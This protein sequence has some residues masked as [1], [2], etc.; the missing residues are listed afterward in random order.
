MTKLKNNK[1]PFNSKF[2]IEPFVE[3][4][5]EDFLQISPKYLE[6]LFTQIN[7]LAIDNE[8]NLKTIQDNSAL[9]NSFFSLV[10]PSHLSKNELKMIT[11][12]MGEELLFFSEKLKQ[13]QPE[14]SDDNKVKFCNISEDELYKYKCILLLN[15]L[16]ENKI[17]YDK[18]ITVEFEDGNGIFKSFIVDDNH[19]F[20]KIFPN[21]PKNV[22]TSNQINELLDD[23]DNYEL[24]K[25]LFPLNSWT[26][27]GFSIFTLI[28]NTIDNAVSDLKTNLL[29]TNLESVFT[30][31]IFKKIFRSI[32]GIK[33][34]KVGVT[35]YNHDE[36]ILI[37][38]KYNNL[39]IDSFI[40]NK[41]E[42]LPISDYKEDTIV[43]RLLNDRQSIVVQDI[44]VYGIG[45]PKSKVIKSLVEQDIKSLIIAPIVSHGLVVGFFEIVSESKHAI[46][47]RNISKLNLVL[48]IVKNT[49]D[50]AIE[51]NKNKIDAIIQNEY[52]SIHKSV[53]WKFKSQASQFLKSGKDIEEYN[54]KDIIFEDVHALFGQIDIK[55]SSENRLNASKDD[56][57]KQLDILIS[58]FNDISKENNLL[59]V[60]QII[61]ELN[62]LADDIENNYEVNSESVFNRYVQ[63]EVHP[64]LNTLE[65]SDKV[66]NKIELYLSQMDEQLNMIYES[67]RKYDES[68]TVLNKKIA[69]YLDKKQIEAQ[70]IFPHYY[71]RYATDGI[72]HNLYIGASIEPKKEFSTIYLNNLRLWQLKTLCETVYNY[73]KWKH[74]LE[75]PLEV[76]T[77]ILVFSTPLNIRFRLEEKLFDVDGSYNARYEVV[78]KRIDKS[79][80]KNTEERITQP[81]KITIVY[82]QNDEKLEYLK[83]LKYLISEDLLEP[84][85]EKLEVEDLQSVT[86]LKALRVTV[87]SID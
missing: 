3:V 78:K 22:P 30:D 32:F 62:K 84:T 69:S 46:K 9:F 76:T 34:L 13:A 60:E 66:K 52:T 79:F 18:K 2:S 11:K 38:P 85:I 53:Y 10:I 1:F 49:I 29:Q 17:S 47:K 40:L 73:Q 25:Q 86:G 87:K 23:F 75:F 26:I 42:F 83:Y 16:L 35:I 64:I 15:S 48:P 28:E 67:R 41:E 54:F 51:E 56:I 6:S 36:D 77:L 5:S 4:W 7:N 19:E 80:I 71:E 33:D 14:T 45:H 12:P 82:S 59:I 31:E 20:V 27:E 24:W 50:K 81:N 55:S 63:N 57:E 74:I 70:Q 68:V 61:F 72:E 58:I 43:K 8:I 21:D 44:E 39:Q 65:F 37:K